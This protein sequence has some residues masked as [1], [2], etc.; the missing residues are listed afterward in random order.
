[1][2]GGSAMAGWQLFVQTNN[3]VKLWSTLSGMSRTV[4]GYKMVVNSLHLTIIT[5]VI[6]I[7]ESNS[8][9]Y[10][11]LMHFLVF[12]VEHSLPMLCHTQ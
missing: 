6:T 2:S 1:M 4:V 11:V 3:G 7:I 9:H 8:N 10:Y 12:D 5:V